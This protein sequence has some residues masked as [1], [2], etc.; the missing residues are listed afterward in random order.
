[1]ILSGEN[2]QSKDMI[3]EFFR[4]IILCHQVKVM[5]DSHNNH[6]KFIGVFNDEIASLEFSQQQNF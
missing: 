5:K 1:M 3:T 6:L 2:N 4:G